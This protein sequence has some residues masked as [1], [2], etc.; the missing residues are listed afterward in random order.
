MDHFA[1]TAGAFKGKDRDFK[2]TGA[3][4]GPDWLS[5][6]GFSAAPP[7]A[8][9]T[10]AASGNMDHFASTAGAFKGKDRDFKATGASSGPDWLSGSAPPAAPAAPAKAG[11]G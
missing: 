1:S 11:G 5:G 8:A 2:A 9:A 3:S 4:S 7:A 6:S 10:A